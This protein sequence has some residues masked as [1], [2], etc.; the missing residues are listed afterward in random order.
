MIDSGQADYAVI[1]AAEGSRYTQEV[2][3]ERLAR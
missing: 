1:V 2:T 3:L